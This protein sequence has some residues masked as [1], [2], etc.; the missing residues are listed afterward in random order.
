VQTTTG[1]L[2]GTTEKRIVNWTENDHRDHIFGHV[3]GKS[4]FIR[5]SKG[6]D[7]K[8][9]PDIDLQT[10]VKDEKILKFLR[11]EIFV[12]GEETEGFV[13]DEPAGDDLGEGE[14]LW[15]QSFVVSQDSGWTAEQVSCQSYRFSYSFC[16]L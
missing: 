10:D 13:V 12:D 1:G 14:G 2:G 7:G 4:R 6:E 8:V 9:R 3:V 16:P 15:L 5:G 11:G